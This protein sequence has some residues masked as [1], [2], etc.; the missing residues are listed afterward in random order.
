M[1]DLKISAFLVDH[2]PV[3]PAFGYQIN[4]KG[5]KVVISGDTKITDSLATHVENANI[6]I[7]EAFSYFLSKKGIK[8]A[9]QE[10][11][12]TKLAQIYET[13]QYHSDTLALAKM[14]AKANVKYL[15]LT[16]LVPTISNNDKAKKTFI[17]GMKRYYK[18]ILIVAD[19]KD[20]LVLSSNS[21]QHCK[22]SYL[23]IQSFRIK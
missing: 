13:K 20:Q 23:P 1:D 4:Y 18:G 11:N 22:V 12:K 10:N 16:H 21:S 17:I 19:D 2:A 6:L 9:K 7:N 5:C 3:F 8:E 15:F 14:A